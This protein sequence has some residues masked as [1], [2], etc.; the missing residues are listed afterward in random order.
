M[1]SEKE[2]GRVGASPETRCLRAHECESAKDGKINARCIQGV[3][4]L[5]TSSMYLRSDGGSISPAVVR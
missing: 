4:P 2:V 1:H 3:I 5:S